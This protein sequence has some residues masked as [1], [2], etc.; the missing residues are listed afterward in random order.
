MSTILGVI[1]GLSLVA[2][3]DLGGRDW[4]GRNLQL[5]RV[6]N[7][8]SSVISEHLHTIRVVIRTT[9]GSSFT[10]IS[11]RLP[12]RPT[13][14][15]VVVLAC[16]KTSPSLLASVLCEANGPLSALPNHQTDRPA[17]PPAPHHQMLRDL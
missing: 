4:F 15:P 6:A 5:R 16:G 14:R 2:M 10:Q 1:V 9:D 11:F 7:N 8:V 12:I 17:R 3:E 13:P